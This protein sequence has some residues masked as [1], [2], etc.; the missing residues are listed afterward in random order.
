[1]ARRNK[2]KTN[3]VARAWL[4]L[5]DTVVDE[6]ASITPGPRASSLREPAKS[7]DEITYFYARARNRREAF[8]QANGPP[9]GVVCAGK[10][11]FRYK[12]G[13]RAFTC[14]GA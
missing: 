9:A 4:Q 3:I 5:G 11:E 8:L 14:S 6:E 10:R 7:D 12:R 1:M 13:D 2:P